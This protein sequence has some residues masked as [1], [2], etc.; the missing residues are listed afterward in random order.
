MLL[1]NFFQE[2]LLQGVA[3]KISDPRSWVGGGLNAEGGGIRQPWLLGP[4]VVSM[5]A[6]YQLACEVSLSGKDL[7]PGTPKGWIQVQ[8]HLYLL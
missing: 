3:G 1:D 7:W 5:L 2:R 6:G 4:H 8:I